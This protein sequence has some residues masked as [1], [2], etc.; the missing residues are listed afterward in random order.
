MDRPR[1]LEGEEAPGS[2]PARPPPGRSVRLVRAA[3]PLSPRRRRILGHGEALAGAVPVP[4]S[5]IRRTDDIRHAEGEAGRDP[6]PCSP[7]PE[8]SG[9][10]TGGA[11][12]L[13]RQAEPGRR[14]RRTAPG[15]GW[16]AAAASARIAVGMVAAGQVEVELRETCAR[17]SAGSR[18]EPEA[19]RRHSARGGNRRR[20]RCRCAGRSR[21]ATGGTRDPAQHVQR[22]GSTSCCSRSRLDI[23]GE[24]RGVA[25]ADA[26]QRLRAHLGAAE[27]GGREHHA[28]LRRE[29][30]HAVEEWGRVHCAW[31][32]QVERAPCASR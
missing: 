14:R 9:A 3:G 7:A 10:P 30:A 13:D 5:A 17:T 29:L 19:R 22:A 16:H 11:A 15:R 32:H 1:R 4:S 8:R 2:A 18:D 23:T 26:V 6:R 27:I 28:G 12:L 31:M 25:A 20:S 21:A 24:D